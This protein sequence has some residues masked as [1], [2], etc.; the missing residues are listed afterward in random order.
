MVRI[1]IC[2]ILKGRAG[3]PGKSKTTTEQRRQISTALDMKP[4]RLGVLP[5]SLALLACRLKNR[6]GGEGRELVVSRASRATAAGQH[7]F[8]IVSEIDGP[9]KTREMKRP[10]P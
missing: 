6:S 4:P 9:V 7:G 2:S 5:R 10:L 3:W 1:I 8:W